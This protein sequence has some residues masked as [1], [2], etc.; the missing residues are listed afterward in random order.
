LISNLTVY[1]CRQAAALGASSSNY[2]QDH[3]LV[4]WNLHLS[5]QRRPM[6]EEPTQ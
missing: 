5:I 6:E 1:Q 3:Q 2:Q 4:D